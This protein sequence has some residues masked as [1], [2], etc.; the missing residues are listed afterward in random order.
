MLIVH[1]AQVSNRNGTFLSHL[2]NTTTGPFFKNNKFS[3]IIF[4]NN[5]HF[6]WFAGIMHPRCWPSRP[7]PI[8]FAEA[9]QL[10]SASVKPTSTYR[11]RVAKPTSSEQLERAG[12]VVRDG[13]RLRRA[14]AAVH[15]GVVIVF[16]RPTRSGGGGARA[17]ELPLGTGAG[18]PPCPA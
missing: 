14:Q 13:A 8:G 10:L 17:R 9:D 11:L 18:E 5:T 12:H 1:F 15:L 2:Q 7:V 6:L 4:R 16:T 3:L